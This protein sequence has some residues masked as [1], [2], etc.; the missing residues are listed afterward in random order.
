MSNQPQFRVKEETERGDLAKSLQKLIEAQYISK[1]EYDVIASTRF[2]K[3][4]ALIIAL[5]NVIRR[6]NQIHMITYREIEEL[7]R[8]DDDSAKLQKDEQREL[9]ESLWNLKKRIMRSPDALSYEI[10]NSFIFMFSLALQSLDGGSRVEGMNISG[11][12]TK[13][14]M[15]EGLSPWERLTGR[16]N[17][18]RGL[19]NAQ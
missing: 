13:K 10:N 7:V 19:F 8:N 9:I 3:R 4:E 5:M 18:N 17:R 15:D 11:G 12:A 14:M 16:V 2:T 6:I 1:K